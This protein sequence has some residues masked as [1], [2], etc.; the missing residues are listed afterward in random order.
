MIKII[1]HRGNIDGPDHLKENDPSFI[2]SALDLGFDVEVD[3]WLMD[4]KYYLGHDEPQY[5]TSLLWLEDRSDK[6]WIH[7]K[8]FEALKSF[9]LNNNLNYFWHQEDKFTLTSKGFI[10]TY[11][12]NEL[13][14]SSVC[15]LPEKGFIGTLDK[16]HA[17][18]TDYPMRYSG[19]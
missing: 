13:G 19:F 12:N 11:P 7:C 17:V 8:N 10:W 14:Q 1:C 4:E 9:S 16:C 5:E 15:V 3:V 6:L 18:C 2:Q